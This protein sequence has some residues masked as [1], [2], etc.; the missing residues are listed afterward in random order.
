[1]KITKSQIRQIIRE[2]IEAIDE[3]GWETSFGKDGK[4]TTKPISQS[5]IDPARDRRSPPSKGKN[6]ELMQTRLKNIFKSIKNHSG[7]LAKIEEMLKLR[8]SPTGK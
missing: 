6:E 4:P 8:G 7:R 1:M 3:A 5:D 2:E